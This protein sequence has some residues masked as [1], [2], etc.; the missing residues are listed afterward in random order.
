M[1]EARLCEVPAGASF[2]IISVLLGG[3]VG[4][5]LADMGFTAGAEGAVVRRGFLNGP[6]Q[7][8]LRGYDLILRRSEAAG[9]AVEP[10]GDWPAVL[11]A[12]RGRGRGQSRGGGTGCEDRRPVHDFESE[13]PRQGGGSACGCE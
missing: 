6:L 8:S 11:G 4:R 3:E 12:V 1:A 7:V 2:R 13:K 5:R 10:V 9:V